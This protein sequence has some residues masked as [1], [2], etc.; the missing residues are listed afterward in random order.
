[1][2]AG[3]DKYERIYAAERN[4]LGLPAPQV[5]AALHRLN[6]PADV[7]DLGCGQGR[8]ALPLARAG[9]RVLAVDMAASGL[10]QLAKDAETED[11]PIICQQADLAGYRPDGRFDL[12]LADRVL[13]MMNPT[14]RLDLMRRTISC[15]KP[16]G[17]V[18]ILDEARNIAALRLL[19]DP[20]SWGMEVQS[21]TCIGARCTDG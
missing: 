21:K 20:E 13:H 5:L 15:L 10:A 12:I 18:L 7:L 19:F 11:L 9:H 16:G 17:R 3:T 2:T 14:D 1:M 8:D 4:A 6:A